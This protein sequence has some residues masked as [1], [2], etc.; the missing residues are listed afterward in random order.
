[1]SAVDNYAQAVWFVVLNEEGR[2]LAKEIYTGTVATLPTILNDIPLH[3]EVELALEEHGELQFQVPHV[4]CIVR[5]THHK[6]G[7]LAKG[8]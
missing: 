8:F 4:H 5:P 2:Q 7:Y 1:M 6:Y 3:L